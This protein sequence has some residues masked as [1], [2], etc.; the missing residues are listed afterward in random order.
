MGAA[1][2]ADVL[3]K[4]KKEAV[5][6]YARRTMDD[7]SED[8]ASSHRGSTA[9]TVAKD[10]GARGTRGAGLAG[11]PLARA[12]SA[13][14]ADPFLD[15]LAGFAQNPQ[16]AKA[17][18]AAKRRSQQAAASFNEADLAKQVRRAQRRTESR[19]REE[20]HSSS[21]KDSA[22]RPSGVASCPA[23][24]P[25]AGAGA[26]PFA[27]C[28]ADEKEDAV[29]SRRAP[30][31]PTRS[32]SRRAMDVAG[33][34][35][36]RVHH[37]RI[38]K[39]VREKQQQR[40]QKKK[41]QAAS[42]VGGWAL[43]HASIYEQLKALPEVGPPIFPEAWTA[44]EVTH[45]DLKSLKRA[46]HRAAA[47]LHPDKVQALPLAS[48]ALAEELFKALGEAYSKELKSLEA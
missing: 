37:Q 31:P 47:K 10:K 41:E 35:G 17:V 30:S 26:S 23:T 11:P 18:Q 42:H 1:L 28:Q 39:E 36:Q 32:I 40:R 48:Q 24:Q 43:A 4:G 15:V 33:R 27:A 3:R 12:P 46:Y 22:R 9:S 13:P 7:D 25:G 29:D 21:F 19:K 34:V 14:I 2:P 5:R 45:G 20:Q 44:G 6:E 8:D 38:A 16:D